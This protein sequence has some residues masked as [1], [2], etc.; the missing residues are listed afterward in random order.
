MGIMDNFR[1]GETTNSAQGVNN[2]PAPRSDAHV[3]APPPEQH[4]R[5]LDF[6]R[7]RG[8]TTTLLRSRDIWLSLLG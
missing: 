4:K 3:N 6:V 2:I 1:S 8:H 5:V 7:V